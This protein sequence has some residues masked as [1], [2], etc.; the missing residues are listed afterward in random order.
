[1]MSFGHH[2][3]MRILLVFILA[4][5]SFSLPAR[6]ANLIFAD[7]LNEEQALFVITVEKYWGKPEYIYR[8]GKDAGV[9]SHCN[10]WSQKINEVKTSSLMVLSL[11]ASDDFKVKD[12]GTGKETLT[13]FRDDRLYYKLEEVFMKGYSS[14]VSEGRSIKRSSP[15]RDWSELCNFIEETLVYERLSQLPSIKIIE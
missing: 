10:G 9:L 14:G 15:R 2:K 1:M 4:M 13:A 3:S 5:T 7:D 6:S 11:L 12:T 8:F